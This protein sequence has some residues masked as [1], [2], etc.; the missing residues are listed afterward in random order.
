ML[1]GGHEDIWVT[2]ADHKHLQ[3]MYSSLY[4]CQN[5]LH[6]CHNEIDIMY[7]Y[8]YFYEDWFVSQWFISLSSMVKTVANQETSNVP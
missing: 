6:T 1:D 7:M 2:S 3:W 8:I 5:E 4:T